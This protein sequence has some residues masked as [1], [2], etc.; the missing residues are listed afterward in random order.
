MVQCQERSG[1]LFAHE[2]TDTASDQC[3]RCK[4][5]VCQVHA[6]STSAEL[7]CTTCA[8][9]DVKKERREERLAES[10]HGDSSSRRRRDRD[11]YDGFGH[12]GSPFFYGT[13]HY[14]GWGT[15]RGGYWGHQHMHRHDFTEADTESLSGGAGEGFEDDIGG[16]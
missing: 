11:D 7:M 13:Y 1:F 5:S 4:K 9:G 12:Y 10:S 14:S 16:S 2:C 3:A 15:Y 8:K 6:H